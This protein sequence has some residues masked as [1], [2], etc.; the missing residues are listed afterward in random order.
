MA[1]EGPGTFMSVSNRGDAQHSNKSIM[2]L[3]LPGIT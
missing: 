3:R 2:F 1:T